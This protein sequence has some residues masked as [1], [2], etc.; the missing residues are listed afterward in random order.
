GIREFYGNKASPSPL[1]RGAYQAGDF[2]NDI[3]DSNK[4]L[5]FTAAPIRGLDGKI[6]GSIETLW[7]TTEQK[8]A[9]QKLVESYRDLRVSEKKYRTM[10]DADPNPI[11]IVDRETLNVRDVNAT[12]IDCYGYSRNEVLGMS[13]S[14]LVHQPDKEI[15]EE[16]KNITLNHSKFYPKKLHKKKGE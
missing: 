2:F 5:F 16:L 3:G 14:S 10:F 6:R 8:E 1:I 12:A 9:E 11:I 4:W 15:L 13:F 7:D